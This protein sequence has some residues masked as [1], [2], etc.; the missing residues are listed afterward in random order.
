[1]KRLVLVGAGHSHARVLKEF[2]RRSP[3]DTQLVLIS[4]EAEA[5]YSGMIPGWLAGYYGWRECCI[6]FDHLCRRAKAIFL[7]DEVV[8]LDPEK[9]E[10]TTAG[11][12]RVGYDRLSLDIG[13]TLNPPPGGEVAVIPMRPLSRLRG[14]WDDL[15]QRTRGLAAGADFRI[16]TVGGGAAGVE[17]TLAVRRRLTEIASHVRFRYTLAAATDEIL[18][19]MAAGAARRIRRHFDRRG[20]DIVTGFSA[21]RIE[22]G[23][24]VASDGRA[25]PANAALWATGAEPYA[26]PR[27]AGLD[28][29]PSGFIRIDGALRT[30][31]HPN[32]FAAGDCAG[33]EQ[34]LPKAGVYAVRMGP[35]LSDN[36]LASLSGRSLRRYAPQ[37]GY[38]ALIG[39]GDGS[40]VAARGPFSWEGAWVW[41]WKQWLDRRF[42][43]VYEDGGRS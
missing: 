14:I 18:P 32:V 19:G 4:P 7:K 2:A 13:S 38:L 34:P 5:P 3:P 29:D 15:Q 12:D 24:I 28:A 26:W 41:R 25:L 36:L 37:I 17:S 39:T 21:V 11:G 35:V 6:D 9:Q 43:S 20:I 22:H 8:A 33:F 40:A 30:L 27:E 42:L 10:V 16:V 1:M 31:S 23:R